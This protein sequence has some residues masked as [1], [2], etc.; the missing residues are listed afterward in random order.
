MLLLALPSGFLRAEDEPELLPPP[1]E[2]LAEMVLP[3]PRPIVP[4]TEVPPVLLAPPHLPYMRQDRWA[5]WQYVDVDRR[6]GYKPRVIYSP[7]GAY[8]LY[9]GKSFPTPHVHP[10]E[11]APTYAR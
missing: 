6:G 11:Y 4:G 9:N 8:Y 7:Q 2:A 5:V 1:R 10:L 3:A